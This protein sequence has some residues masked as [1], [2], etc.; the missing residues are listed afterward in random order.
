MQKRTENRPTVRSILYFA[1]KLQVMR[2]I[3][4]FWVGL[5]TNLAIEHQIHW[6][7]DTTNDTPSKH[8][9]EVSRTM[10]TGILRVLYKQYMSNTGT[11]ELLPNFDEACIMFG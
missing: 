8:R 6:W 9:E 3:A 4:H 11:S 1:K 2:S 5:S 10:I 7:I